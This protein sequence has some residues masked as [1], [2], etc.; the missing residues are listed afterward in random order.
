MVATF[1]RMD[2]IEEASQNETNPRFEL[3]TGQLS[4]SSD[5]AARKRCPR[6]SLS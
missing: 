4:F 3:W 6:A 1:R 5:E 2:R